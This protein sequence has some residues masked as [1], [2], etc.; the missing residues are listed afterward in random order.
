M[1][2][3]TISEADLALCVSDTVG[4]GFSCYAKEFPNLQAAHPRTPQTWICTIHTSLEAREFLTWAEMCARDLS[5]KGA[6]PR[7]N[8]VP[9]QLKIR[10]GRE[11]PTLKGARFSLRHSGRMRSHSGQVR[12]ETTHTTLKP[13]PTAARKMARALKKR[14]T[15]IYRVQRG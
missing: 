13:N 5:T 10:H 4:C 12:H 1:F 14:L 11:S 8:E 9:C 7:N 2:L 6:L 3:D 15:L